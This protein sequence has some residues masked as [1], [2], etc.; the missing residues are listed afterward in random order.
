MAILD[1]TAGE[2]A[3]AEA[4]LRAA[5]QEQRD[6]EKVRDDA[7]ETLRTVRCRLLP[8]HC[9]HVLHM[10]HTCVYQYLLSVTVFS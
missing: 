4:D 5:L 10:H 2:T 9:I 7:L 3:R 8:E 6:A 1:D